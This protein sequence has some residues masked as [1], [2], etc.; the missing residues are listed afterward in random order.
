MKVVLVADIHFHNYKMFAKNNGQSVNSRLHEHIDAMDI[1]LK[2]CIEH[3]IDRLWILGDLFHA[4]DKIDVAVNNAVYR[5]FKK[6]KNKVN[7]TLLVGNHGLNFKGQE[8]SSLPLGEIIEIKAEPEAEIIDGVWVFWLP[9][10]YGLDSLDKI[11]GMVDGRGGMKKILLGHFGVNGAIVQKGYRPR[12][13]I[14]VSDIERYGFDMVFLGDYHKRQF[15]KDNILYV[16]S[17]CHHDF[18]EVGYE[19]GFIVLELDDLF[20]ESYGI[21]APKFIEVDMIEDVPKGG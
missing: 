5:L 6:Y 17:L 12:S 7:T 16:G 9:A 19:D 15:V 2:Y 13:E 8:V 4:R 18:R 3:N 1:V 10:G 21:D 14:E 11:M 20:Y